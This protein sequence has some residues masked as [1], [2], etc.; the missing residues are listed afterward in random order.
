MALTQV[1]GQMLNG[2]TNTVTTIQ[3]NG[4]TAVTID[5]SQNVGIGT[6]SP[7]AKL[8]VS[9]AGGSSGSTNL[10]Y[11]D[12]T[13][14]YGGISVNSTANNNSFVELLE[15][16]TKVGGFNADTTNNVTSIQAAGGHALGFNYNN[17]TEAMRINTAGEITTNGASPVSVGAGT[18]VLTLK[19]VAASTPWGVGPTS[20]FGNFYVKATTGN[21]VVLTSTA[22]SWASDSDE[23][24]KTAITPFEKPLDKVCSLRAGTGSYLADESKLSRSFLIAQDVQ[25][26]LPEA[27]EEGE[28]E[29]KTLQLRYT[30]IIP[31]LVASIKQLNAKVDA[32]AAEI[33]ALKAQ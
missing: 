11:V 6:A 27:V 17:T 31:L 12:V 8:Q 33:K 10:V 18:H 23:R 32:Q 3:S 25:K 30:E 4:T 29:D 28:D 15:A 19:S 1:Q 24:K 14:S 13:S 16:G 5:A 7:T 20:S 9:R 21:G 2:S 26:V 22:T